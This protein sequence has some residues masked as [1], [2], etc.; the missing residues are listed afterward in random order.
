MTWVVLFI[1]SGN[2]F[3]FS[4][5]DCDKRLRVQVI[6]DRSVNIFRVIS[7]IEDVDLRFSRSVTLNEE[8]FRMRD[9]MDRLLG[10]LEPG[11]G[12]SISID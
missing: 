1:E 8:F 5:S 2:P 7:F 6:P 10:D 11:N 12:L 4:V 9:I 3:P